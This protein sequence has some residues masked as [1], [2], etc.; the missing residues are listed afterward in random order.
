MR[1]IN[2][3][4]RFSSGTGDEPASGNSPSPYCCS[5]ILNIRKIL[6]K[7]SKTEHINTS[8]NNN[9]IMVRNIFTGKSS[10]VVRVLLS[11]P[12][13]TWRTREL[14]LEAKASLGT[15]STVTNKLIDMGFLVRDRST[16]LKLRKEE[17]LVRRWASFYDPNNLPHKTYYAQGTVYEIG[18]ALAKTAM[19]YGL[20][21]AFTGPF[22]TDLL[23]QY[24]RPAEIHMYLTNEDDLKKVVDDLSLEIA[25][26]GG[27]VIFLIAEDESVLYGLRNTTDDRVGTVSVV[28]DVQLILDLY[29]LTDRTREAAERL[30]TKNLER[31]T[32]GMNLI[33]LATRFFEQK[34]LT[35]EK[36]RTTGSAQE[37]DIILFDPKTEE[38]ILVECKNTTAKLE[39]VDQL[40]N[41]IAS[42]P[43]K[44][45]GVLVA[46]RITDAAMKELEK[47]QLTFEPIE[48]IE[49]G[50]HKGTS[51]NILQSIE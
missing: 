47:A 13:E 28:S 48:A 15:V 26:I 37:A 36:G 14:A 46:P 27:N 17:E 22:A 12:T 32:Q 44:A 25:E 31:K 3:T 34:G 35:V 1:L 30:L 7:F 4:N 2:F 10:R 16:R 45:K 18:R 29:N 50:L 8:L 24:I 11:K 21:Y 6:N 51:R 42:F 39:A 23:T 49:R 20:K 9:H 33:E 43:K 38:Y 19:R 41:A 5:K 40:K